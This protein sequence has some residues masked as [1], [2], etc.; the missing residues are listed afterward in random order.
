MR[1][2]ATYHPIVFLIKKLRDIYPNALS[3][4]G[5]Y[6]EKDTTFFLSNTDRVILSDTDKLR[7]SKLQQSEMAF[8]WLDEAFLFD[9]KSWYNGGQKNISDETENRCL[10]MRLPSQT[11]IGDL[12]FI[13][14]PKQVSLFNKWND[15]QSI[16]A[17]EKYLLGE[18]ISQSIRFDYEQLKKEQAILRDISLVQ[19]KQYAEKHKLN[20]DYTQLE[21]VYLEMVEA[22]VL[23]DLKEMEQVLNVEFLLTKPFLSVLANMKLSASELKKTLRE[24]LDLAFSMNFG[25]SQIELSPVYIQLDKTSD[26]V[27]KVIDKAEVLLNNYETSAKKCIM[28]GV[29]INGKNIAEH[30]ETPVSP[31]AINFAIRSNAN[32]IQYLLRQY[33]EKWSLIKTGLKTLQQFDFKSNRIA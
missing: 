18:L 26:T 21:Q 17:S 29:K 6:S 11:S 7:V 32:R 25:N 10:L 20:N 19:K 8:R 16:T 22:L 30:L 13:S 28:L 23:S 4:G 12:L 31:P 9:S 2:S 15:F 5:V 1:L 27:S 14:F 24:S 33:P 3:I